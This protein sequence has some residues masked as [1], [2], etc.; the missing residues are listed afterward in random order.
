MKFREAFM[1]SASF[2]FIYFMYSHFQL[3]C[4]QI[5]VVSVW[6]LSVNGQSSTNCLNLSIH[7]F[8]IRDLI[9][10]FYYPLATFRVELFK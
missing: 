4:I 9:D 10:K 8:F 1:M 5:C 6:L 2:R 7:N 3:W